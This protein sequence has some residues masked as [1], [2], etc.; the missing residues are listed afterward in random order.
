MEIEQ[1]D[2]LGRKYVRGGVEGSSKGEGD[3]RGW[4]KKVQEGRL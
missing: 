3:I 1:I 4:K 2:D